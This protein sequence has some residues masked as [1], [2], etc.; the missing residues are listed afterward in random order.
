MSKLPVSA[1]NELEQVEKTTKGILFTSNPA[2]GFPSLGDDNTDITLNL[3][4]YLV[5]NPPSTFFVKVAGDSMEGAGIFSGDI[6]VVDRSL[7][8][9]HR[10]VVVAVI[11][12]GLVV[13]RLKI[14]DGKQWLISENSQYEPIVIDSEEGC[15]IWGVV[16][17]S[18]RK[19]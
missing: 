9:E 11:E 3:H 18:V 6:L 16:V 8:P 1:K 13:K 15:Y 2:A 5:K 17:G 12:G 14:A 19:F 7:S 4:E 10:S